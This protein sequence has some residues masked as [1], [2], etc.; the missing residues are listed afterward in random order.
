MSHVRAALDAARQRPNLIVLLG[1]EP[2]SPEP[3]YGWIEPGAIQGEREIYG[4]RRFWEKPERFMARVL[5]LRGV[6]P[7]LG[8]RGAL[9]GGAGLGALLGGLRS[10]RSGEQAGRED[11]GDPQALHAW[12]MFHELRARCADGPIGEA[13]AWATGVVWARLT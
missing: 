4:V 9:P 8:G 10:A 2:E 7:R 6:H 1:V 12:R 13:V 3:D 5:Q 11:E